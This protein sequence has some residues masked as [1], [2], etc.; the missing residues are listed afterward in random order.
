L[1]KFRKF[2]LRL[3][4]LLQATKGEPKFLGYNWGTKSLGD[5]NT[6]P[7]SPGGGENAMLITSHFKQ[8][9]RCK[10]ER[11]ENRT[12]RERSLAEFSK[13]EIY[14][15]ENAL[16]PSMMMILTIQELSF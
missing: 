12:V 10:I 6:G 8:N 14:G 7:T 3:G 2:V 16:F 11:R 9:Y 1:R 5:I 4:V 13:K 15:S